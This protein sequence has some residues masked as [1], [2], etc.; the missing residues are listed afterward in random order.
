LG[1]PFLAVGVAVA[2]IRASA[3][4]L[5]NFSR[6]HFPHFP[7]Q[8]LQFVFQRVRQR[9]CVLSRLVGNLMTAHK[10]KQKGGHKK[11][12]GSVPKDQIP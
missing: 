3:S 12:G 5:V 9:V 1:R 6:D 8:L 7:K 4:V 11:V 2:T 10:Q